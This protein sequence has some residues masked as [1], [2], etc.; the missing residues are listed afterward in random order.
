MATLSYDPK[1]KRGLIQWEPAD[2]PRRSISVTGVT[3]AAA[4]T[5][6]GHVT[7]LVAAARTGTDPRDETQKWLASVSPEFH[8]YL[9]GKG[10]VRPRTTVA[11]N[12]MDLGKFFN[13]YIKRRGDVKPATADTYR[14]ARKWMVA[15]FGELKDAR[16]FTRGDVLDWQRYL[17]SKV[18]AAYA[19]K[20][21]KKA[22]QVF[23]DAV[24]HEKI[25]HTPFRKIKLGGMTNDARMRYV[26]A[27]DVRKVIDDCPD[28]E[29]RMVFAL[30]RFA[31]LRVPSELRG[32][33]WSDVSFPADDLPGKLTARSP[34]TER[35]EG[36]ASRVVPIAPELAPLL[37]EAFDAADDGA[38]F[39]L[40]RLRRVTNLWTTAVKLIDRA[41]VEKWPK[42][43]QNL[44]S[45]REIDWNDRHPEHVVCAWMGHSSR[46]ARK[47]YLRVTEDHYR[48]ASFAPAVAAFAGGHRQSSERASANPPENAADRE[49]SVAPEGPHRSPDSPTKTQK[50]VS[51]LRPVL[52]RDLS[53]VTRAGRRSGG[54]PSL[55][56][57]LRRIATLAKGGAA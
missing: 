35:Y 46:T 50:S 54:K 10:L 39:V 38:A 33:R 4:Q 48:A 27:A 20:L 21:V 51:A 41:G 22:A 28:V 53:R 40:P 56:R 8:A 1:A 7:G 19:D 12:P 49:M 25:P 24:D 6:R 16:T 17:H 2:G 3:R 30:A 9:A 36:R 55:S 34:K 57:S 23:A 52:H 42:T 47:H 43:F 37:L 32:L 13:A 15:R 29:W 26:P 5:I 44:R 31:G 18:S 45:S 11:A 14:Q